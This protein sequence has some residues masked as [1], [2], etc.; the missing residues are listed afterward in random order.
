MLFMGQRKSHPIDYRGDMNPQQ[1][2]ASVEVVLSRDQTCVFTAVAKQ[3]NLS[4]GEAVL[5]CAVV[6]VNLAYEDENEFQMA[7]FEDGEE[8]RVRAG[9]LPC[10]LQIAA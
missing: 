5:R 6:A 2:P 9:R 7:L 10:G 8:P 3:C 1:Y 4:L